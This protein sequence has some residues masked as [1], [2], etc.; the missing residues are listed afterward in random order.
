MLS[1]DKEWISAK[2]S[3]WRVG[4]TAVAASPTCTVD[5]M[6]VP[7]CHVGRVCDVSGS[8]LGLSVHYEPAGSVSPAVMG[9]ERDRIVA[10]LEPWLCRV[11]GRAVDGV[12]VTQKSQFEPPKPGNW[13]P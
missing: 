6:M 1:Q 8:R 7:L 3:E 5:A 10:V 13:L 11:G 9:M 2:W 12:C 4:R